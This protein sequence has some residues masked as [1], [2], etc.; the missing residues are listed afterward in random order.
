MSWT[1]P[2]QI[3]DHFCGLR[4]KECMPRSE[5][6]IL[7]KK[8]RFIGE[9]NNPGLGKTKTKQNKRKSSNK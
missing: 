8:L 5:G 7:S 9:D 6:C 2:H 3:K 1:C 4:K